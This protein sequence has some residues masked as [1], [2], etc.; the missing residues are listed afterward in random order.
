MLGDVTRDMTR[1]MLRD[2]IAPVQTPLR[3]AIDQNIVDHPAG[4]ETSQ[5]FHLALNMASLQELEIAYPNDGGRKSL[6]I[7][8]LYRQKCGRLGFQPLF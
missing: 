8:T 2:I 1:D 4:D 3:L 6:V 5:A 7:Q